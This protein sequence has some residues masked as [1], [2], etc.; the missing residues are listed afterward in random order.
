VAHNNLDRVSIPLLLALLVATPAGA[1]IYKH[2]D[3]NGTV[4]YTNRS[5]TVPAAR[6]WDPAAV[7]GFNR[8]E[9]RG[10]QQL[11]GRADARLEGRAP[12][13]QDHA[14]GTRVRF[15]RNGS[16]MLVDVKLNDEVMAPF[17]VDSGCSG[18]SLTGDVAAALG[19]DG[20]PAH[21]F[22]A[23]QTANGTVRLAKVQLD[24]VALGSARVADVAATINPQLPV[25]LLGGAFLNH[26]VYSVDPISGV[27]ILEPRRS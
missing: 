9:A 4:V 6:R 13:V 19:L 12:S 7:Q 26:F 11:A 10:R 20:Q 5:E 18:I 21:G 3:A 17:Y 25:G 8:A 16:L 22:Q 23:T 27:L 2:V 15:Q 1:E 24:S 14:D